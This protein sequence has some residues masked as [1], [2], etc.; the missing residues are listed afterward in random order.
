[1]RSY[2]E[3]HDKLLEMQDR[4]AECGNLEIKGSVEALEW[5]IGDREDL[6]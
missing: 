2:Q 6:D 5:I 4:Y 1:M 3:V